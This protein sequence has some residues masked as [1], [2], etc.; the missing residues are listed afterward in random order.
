MLLSS[1]LQLIIWGNVVNSTK[2][3]NEFVLKI[4]SNAKIFSIRI[5]IRWIVNLMFG[6]T[7]S[8]LE[9]T[10]KIEDIT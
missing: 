2:L 10:L 4:I 7:I 3:Q 6:K 5:L 1:N 9:K 8:K